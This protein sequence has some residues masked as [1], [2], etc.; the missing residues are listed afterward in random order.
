MVCDTRPPVLVTAS[1]I[2]NEDAGEGARA[3]HQLGTHHL[4]RYQ[5]EDVT[6]AGNGPSVRCER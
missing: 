1:Q 3:T 5:L 6:C 2:D 4:A